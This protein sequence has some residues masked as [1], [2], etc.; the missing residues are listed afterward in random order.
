M[1]TG[2]IATAKTPGT[3]V[4]VC[5]LNNVAVV[6]AL[7]QGVSVF[8]VF[9][10]MNP[11]LVAQVDTPGR[12]L[13]VACEGR[14]VAVADDF[15]GLAVIDIGDPAAARVSHQVGL[16]SK[17]TA[18]AA[19]AGV[20]YVGTSVGLVVAV[21]MAT[22][23]VP[24]PSDAVIID[25]PG[26][27]KVSF[28]EGTSVIKSLLCEEALELSGGTLEVAETVR[29]NNEFVLT[30]Q[31]SAPGDVGA[32][33]RRAIVFAGMT[34]WPVVVRGGRLAYFD[35]VTLNA[36]LRVE[37]GA[38][39]RV[40]NGLALNNTLTLD[41]RSGA[42]TALEF[43]GT[44]TLAGQGQVVFTGLNPSGTVQPTSGTLTIESGVTIRG[45]SG[46][47]GNPALPL[48]NEGTIIAD[49]ADH[50][51]TIRANPFVNHG[52]VSEANGGKVLLPP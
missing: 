1:Q 39:L 24:G 15:A 43:S 21:D 8:N 16:G 14:L 10:G 18:V 28:S 44:Q 17:A 23:A 33:L 22:G 47:I 26:E 37:S 20:A 4:D 2:I 36:S 49:V 30:R 29:F 27:I 45:G 25:V 52:S 32:T 9:N 38:R 42:Y 46:T 41:E 35:E 12:A 51:L 6:A 40:T 48:V 34:A 50:T 5:A 19:G 7:E 3:A 13:R 11:I 31:D